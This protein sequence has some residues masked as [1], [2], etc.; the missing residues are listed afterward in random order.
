MTADDPLIAYE[1][2]VSLAGWGD[3]STRGRTITLQLHDNGDAHPFSASRTRSGKKPGQRYQIVLVE[4]GDDERPVEKT[5]SQMA[6]LLCRDERFQHFLNERS[7][8][9]VDDEDS[10]RAFVLEGCGGI[11]SRS[12]LDTNPGARAAWMTLFFNPFQTYQ[13]RPLL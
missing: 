9:T 6:W 2:E 5:P 12:E 13:S 3:T 7:F 10:A 4:I 8:V 11:K 1:G